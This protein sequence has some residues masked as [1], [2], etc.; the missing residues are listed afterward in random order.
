M[1]KLS[2]NFVLQRIVHIEESP[3]NKTRYFVEIDVKEKT[4]QLGTDLLIGYTSAKTNPSVDHVDF[5]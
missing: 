5:M 1:A 2:G 4:H 3:Q